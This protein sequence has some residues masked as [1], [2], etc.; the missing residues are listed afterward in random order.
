[1]FDVLGALDLCG[2]G[3]ILMEKA[4]EKERRKVAKVK[5]DK[6]TFNNQHKINKGED[7][8]AGRKKDWRSGGLDILGAL[9]VCA[10]GAKIMEQMQR[11]EEK[12]KEA[13]VKRDKRSFNN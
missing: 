1:V 11:E 10:R 9:E 4:L 7:M 13:K 5:R 6:R 2:E 8:K 12:K 3:A